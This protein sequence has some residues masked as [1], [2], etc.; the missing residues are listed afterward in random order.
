MKIKTS[1][2]SETL[3]L[4]DCRDGFWLYDTT[5]GMNLAKRAKNPTAA[6]VEALTYY[7]RRLQEVEHEHKMLRT[8]V[9][10]FIAGIAA[11]NEDLMP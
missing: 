10:G 3:T 4:S 6:F 9:E 5:R 1:E 11:D 7:Q 2:L 8:K